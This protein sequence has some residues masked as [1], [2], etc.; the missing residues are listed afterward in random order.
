M[1]TR[2]EQLVAE[3]LALD[4][5]ERISLIDRVLDSLDRADPRIDARWADECEARVDAYDRGEICAVPLQEA[6]AKYMHR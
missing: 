2:T 3:A 5:P 1:T 4:P 6:L